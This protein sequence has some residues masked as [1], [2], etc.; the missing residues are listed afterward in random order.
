M[1]PEAAAASIFSPTYPDH[2]GSCP[3]PPP[4]IMDT[5]LE[6]CRVSNTT[7]SASIRLRDGFQ[8]MRPLRYLTTRPS[9]FVKRCFEDMIADLAARIPKIKMIRMDGREGAA[10][11]E[12]WD[13]I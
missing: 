7:L 4:A 9:A 5:F 8:E 12:L 2:A 6:E 3:A 10:S 11:V 13:M 1:S